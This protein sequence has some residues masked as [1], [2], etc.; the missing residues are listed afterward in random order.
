MILKD[1]HISCV[2]I[3]LWDFVNVVFKGCLFEVCV[4]QNRQRF[5]LLRLAVVSLMGKDDIFL[6]NSRI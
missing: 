5:I 6:E 4:S 1:L 3:L 2:A